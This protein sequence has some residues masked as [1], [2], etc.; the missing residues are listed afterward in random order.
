MPTESFY[1]LG[2]RYD[3]ESALR[4]LYELKQRPKEKAMPLIIGSMEALTHIAQSIP[5]TAERLIEKF[6]PGPLTILMNAVSGLSEFITSGTGK[7]AV[8]IPGKSFALE[9]VK[10]LEFPVTATSANISGMPPAENPG[11]VVKYFPNSLDILVDG[12]LTPGGVAS[13]IVDVT[14]ERPVIVR[15]GKI[16]EEMM[17]SVLGK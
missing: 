10:C 12:G 16:T 2:V 5:V 3:D 11:E 9:L 13:T 1:G 6:W 14:T 7:V 17:L 15:Q 4:R 8:R